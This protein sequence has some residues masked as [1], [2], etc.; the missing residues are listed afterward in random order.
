MAGVTGVNRTPEPRPDRVAVC[1]VTHESAAELEGWW[2][3]LCALHELEGEPAFRVLVVDCASTDDTVARLRHLTEERPGPEFELIDSKANLGFAG[4]MNR[5]V[6]QTHGVDRWIL[7]LNPDARP[8]PGALAAMKTAF[9]AYRPASPTAPDGDSDWRVGSVTARLVRPGGEVVDACGMRWTRSWRH[10]DRGS[11][12]PNDGR[13]GMAEEVFAGTGAGTMYLREALLDVSFEADV[14]S[15]VAEPRDGRRNDRGPTEIFAEDFHSFRE[16]AEL[17]LR[18]QRRGWRCVYEPA[19]LLE[20]RRTN[21]PDRRRSMS[22][23]VNRN[24]L[25]NRYLL[26]LW[27]Q[28][29]GNTLRTLPSFVRDLGILGYVLLRERESLAAYVWLWRNRR[30]LLERRRALARRQTVPWERVDRWFSRD[31]FALSKNATTDR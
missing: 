17:G 6:A 7:A 3:A 16:D 26:R 11:G 29:A 25:K 9:T 13:Y 2:Q 30:C 31:G 1:T 20:H 19:A 8:Q 22:P 27:H 12:E 21:T 4:G 28:S 23:A 14:P 5:A 10:L 15:G 18:L 24:S